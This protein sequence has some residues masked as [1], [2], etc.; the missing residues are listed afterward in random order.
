MPSATCSRCQA[1]VTYLDGLVGNLSCPACGEHILEGRPAPTRREMVPS[2]YTRDDDDDRAS[3]ASKA[4]PAAAR[5]LPDGVAGAGT[6]WFICGLIGLVL[7]VILLLFFLVGMSTATP[8]GGPSADLLLIGVVLAFLAL[9]YFPSIVGFGYG[10]SR[11]TFAYVQVPAGYALVVALGLLVGYTLALFVL[12]GTLL[13]AGLGGAIP[14]LAL[15]LL[16]ASILADSTLLIVAAILIRAST[17]LLWQS[18][19]YAHAFN[20][21]QNIQKGSWDERRTEYPS[22]ISSAAVLWLLLGGVGVLGV[23]GTFGT[24]VALAGLNVSTGLVVLM[25][26][27]CLLIPLLTTCYLGVL[28]LTG[29][30]PSTLPAGITFLLLSIINIIANLALL[31]QLGES[32]VPLRI[33]AGFMLPVAWMRLVTYVQLG[34]NGLAFLASVLCIAGDEKYRRWL[35]TERGLTV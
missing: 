31:G 17:V 1:A 9:V 34:L 6:A 32:A 25:G 13:A 22:S 7:H 14:P 11:G 27:E 35:R 23:V 20:R 30:L 10:I 12:L 33:E 26:V 15:A 28:L 18:A 4:R 16:F 29:R 24:L 8:L 2:A 3:P 5:G 21:Q 19:Q